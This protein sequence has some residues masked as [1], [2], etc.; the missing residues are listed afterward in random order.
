MNVD[1]ANFS[2]VSEISRVGTTSVGVGSS[3]QLTNNTDG[4]QAGGFWLKTPIDPARDFSSRFT[5]LTVAPAAGT[6][7]NGFTFTI[8]NT[9]TS[10]LGSCGAGLG[11]A[12]DG[13]NPNAAISPS[14]SYAF[15][16]ADG[17]AVLDG[18]DGALTS[19]GMTYADPHNGTIQQAWVDYAAATH[20]LSLF[21]AAVNA[22]KPST[23]AAQRVIAD[24]SAWS[25]S[26]Y[27]GFTG[28]TGTDL[29]TQAVK[30][31]SVHQPLDAPG[32]VSAV[33]GAAGA[34]AG[35]ATVTV[36]W[37]PPADDPTSAAVTS[38]TVYRSTDSSARGTSVG[39]VLV[40]SLADASQPS[41]VDGNASGG[42]T[43]YYTVTD[44]AHGVESPGTTSGQVTAPTT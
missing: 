33:A 11:Y 36:S 20:T 22:A 9:G 15:D 29:L 38:Y 32:A 19:T 17:N 37:S 26:T 28:G 18:T 3:L 25:G 24:L 34:A 35:H 5:Y 10:A 27:L 44:T 13:C 2:D 41:F 14:E 12:A 43:Y 6:A 39:T 42:A 40:S 7:G 31:W 1:F 4:N 16:A 8:Q 21:T 23:P 30:S